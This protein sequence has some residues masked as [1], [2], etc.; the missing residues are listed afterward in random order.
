MMRTNQERIGTKMNAIQEKK[1][2][3]VRDSIVRMKDGR[4]ERTAGQQARD[5]SPEKMEPHW[6]VCKSAIALY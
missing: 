2:A 5:A 6:R 1:D 4:K 3:R